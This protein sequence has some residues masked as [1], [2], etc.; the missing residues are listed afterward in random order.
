MAKSNLLI[1]LLVIFILPVFIGS[2]DKYSNQS[3]NE[4]NYTEIGSEYTD[5]F[6]EGMG[7]ISVI[8]DIG[9]VS[10]KV[11]DYITD[12]IDWIMGAFESVI[13][14]F[15]ELLNIKDD[16]RDLGDPP[17]KGNGSHFPNTKP[18]IPIE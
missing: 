12:A 3:Y 5:Y 6:S 17:Y 14:F 7:E 11:M 10:I 1:A 18:G 13:D 2:Y 9:E 4:M 15:K 8:A 16:G